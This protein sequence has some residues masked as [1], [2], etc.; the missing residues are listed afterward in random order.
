MERCRI[1]LKCH[2]L[3]R[4]FA[5]EVLLYP[6]GVLFLMVCVLL[7]YK[8]HEQHGRSSFPFWVIVGVLRHFVVL[9]AV[10]CARVSVFLPVGCGD[11]CG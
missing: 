6:G 8:H 4:H 1:A 7:C 11:G 3:E 9:S 2:S 5:V 10:F